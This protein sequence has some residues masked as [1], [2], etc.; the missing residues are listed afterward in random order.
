VAS[1]VTGEA[2]AISIEPFRADRDGL[3]MSVE[4]SVW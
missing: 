4:Q 2:P 3:R 1:L